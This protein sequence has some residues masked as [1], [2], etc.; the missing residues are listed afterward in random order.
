MKRAAILWSDVVDTYTIKGTPLECFKDI[1]VAY[2][3]LCEKT[4]VVLMARREH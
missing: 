2:L 4:F 3:L 1:N